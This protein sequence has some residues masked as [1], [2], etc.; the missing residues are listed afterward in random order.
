MML[1]PVVSVI[2]PHWNVPVPVPSRKHDSATMARALEPA[3]TGFALPAGETERRP[4]ID[5]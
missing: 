1:L 4:A 5:R 2:T 3:F